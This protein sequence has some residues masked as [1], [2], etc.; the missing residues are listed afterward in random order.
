[1]K[2]LILIPLMLV[3]FLSSC[4]STRSTLPENWTPEVVASG[5]TDSTG[6]YISIRAT[7]PHDSTSKIVLGLLAEGRFYVNGDSVCM[8]LI[9]VR[10]AM[11]VIHA[12]RIEPLCFDAQKWI[13]QILGKVG[14]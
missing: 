3:V 14:E 11:G 1:M 2:R 9:D 5:R 6:A 8:E 7:L 10:E 13:R 12:P 4:T